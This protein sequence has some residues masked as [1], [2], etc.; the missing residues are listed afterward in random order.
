MILGRLCASL[1]G[2]ML[3]EKGIRRASKGVNRADEGVRIGS[4]ET[5][6]AEQYFWYG[7][8]LEI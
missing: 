5:N 7:L 6:R 8:I 4:E 2:N 3:A 1:L